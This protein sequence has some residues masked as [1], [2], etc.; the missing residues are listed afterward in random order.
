MSGINLVVNYFLSYTHNLCLLDLL[1]RGNPIS[2]CDTSVKGNCLCL[3][4]PVPSIFL[5]ISFTD[6]KMIVHCTALLSTAFFALHWSSFGMENSRTESVLIYWA[7]LYRW[8]S[9]WL[10]VEKLSF[11]LWIINCWPSAV[12]GKGSAVEPCCEKPLF[13]H[14]YNWFLK[15]VY[16]HVLTGRS[17]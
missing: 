17:G 11:L 10:S 5:L 15:S 3:Q 1:L 8:G 9:D 13:Y 12:C 7:W 16:S 2:P 6:Q 4:S 14:P